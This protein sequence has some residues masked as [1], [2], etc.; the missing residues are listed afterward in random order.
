MR[1]SAC[2]EARWWLLAVPSFHEHHCFE[3]QAR[4]LC[5]DGGICILKVTTRAG[6]GYIYVCCSCILVLITITF[7]QQD[8]QLRKERQAP[9]RHTFV[10]HPPYLFNMFIAYGLRKGYSAY[11][12]HQ[13]KKAIEEQSDGRDLEIDSELEYHQ[14]HQHGQDELKDDFYQRQNQ[15]FNANPAQLQQPRQ[16]F[17]T[18]D[19]SQ[20]PPQYAAAQQQRPMTTREREARYAEEHKTLKEKQKTNQVE[21]PNCHEKKKIDWT[22]TPGQWG[23]KRCTC[24]MCKTTWVHASEA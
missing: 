16:F 18:F 4:R 15:G 8:Q 23:E 7:Q 1:P 17:D 13:E 9:I 22:T 6:G 19:Q 20:Q 3:E 2:T 12:E 21:C 14:R 24:L 10:T 11:K 5:Q